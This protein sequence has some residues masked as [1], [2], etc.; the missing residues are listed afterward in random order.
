MRLYIAG[1]NGLGN[2]L[3]RALFQNAAGGGVDEMRLYLAA[4][5]GPGGRYLQGELFCDSTNPGRSLDRTSSKTLTGGA[6]QGG[7]AGRCNIL[8]S[9]YYVADWQTRNI[10]RFKRFLLDSGA[11]TALYGAGMEAKA[12]P[13]YVDRYIRYICE[14]N[15]QDFFEMDVDSVVGYKRV[16]EFRREIEAQTGRRCIPVWH[17]ERGK[18]AFQEMCTEYPYV[19]IGGIATKDGRKRLKPYLRWFTREAH[20]LGAKV[21]GLGYTELKT[22]P[23]VGFDSVDSTAWLYGNRG[24]YIYT[25]D[26]V[27]I[28][29]VN[30]PKGHRLKTREA[31]IHNFTEWLRYAEYLEANDKEW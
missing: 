9:Y 14:N 27:A 20:R 25:F 24:G 21:H 23:S 19:A 7:L 29:K 31:V 10:H 2:Y 3:E 16:L 28:C 15:V 1:T 8:E 5:H 6:L 4:T 13:A 18:R 12:L 11:F 30:A 22:L 26:G 17:L